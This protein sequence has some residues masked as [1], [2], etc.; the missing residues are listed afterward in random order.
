MYT[1]YKI[2]DG[3][4]RT[5]I[6]LSRDVCECVGDMIAESLRENGKDIPPVLMNKGEYGE[7]LTI[8][9]IKDAADDDSVILNNVL[10]S[11]KNDTTEID[12]ILLNPKGVFVFESKNYSGWI[13]GS[14]NDLFWYQTLNGNTKNK[15]Y[16]PIK[17][18]ETHIEAL[19]RCCDIPTE[20]I[21]SYIVF[22]ERCVLKDVPCST[23]KFRI[24]QRGELKKTLK[25][26]LDSLNPIFEAEKIACIN[27]CLTQIEPTKEHRDEHIKNIEERFNGDKCPLCGS[28]LVLRNGKYGTFYGCSSYPRCKYTRNV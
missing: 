21:H 17:Q 8:K 23:N 6:R 1:V 9:K 14:E 22:S 2:L 4:I 27:N 12:V 26:D 5:T 11:Y 7:Y 25:C 24:I 19:A 10:L 18:N 20:Y 13:F 3:I 16:N 28:Y 15:F